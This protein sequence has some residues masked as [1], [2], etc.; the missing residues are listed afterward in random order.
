MAPARVSDADLASF[1]LLQHDLLAGVRDGTIPMDRAVSGLR[2]V[3]TGEPPPVP[4]SELPPEPPPRTDLVHGAYIPADEILPGFCTRLEKLGM[5]FDRFEWLGRMSP[6]PYLDDPEVGVF[7]DVTL[8][9]ITET[10]KFGERWLFDGHP[11]GDPT[12]R[13]FSPGPPEH[14]SLPEGAPEFVPWTLAWRRLR[15]DTNVDWL[16][17]RRLPKDLPGTACLMFLAQQLDYVRMMGDKKSGSM[18]LGGLR[19]G[20]ARK[21]AEE[22]PHPPRRGR[23]PIRKA[24]R[25]PE[26]NSVGDHVPFLHRFRVGPRD[27]LQEVHIDIRGDFILASRAVSSD[28]IIPMYVEAGT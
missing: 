13:L 14:L 18:I 25:Q 11:P 3:L 1:I 22:L 10:Y 24:P 12:R 21:V 9:D 27:G 2:G 6:L 7:L 20:Q 4:L 19:C 8:G 15:P 28:S 17:T 5:S 23:P 26:I 16:N